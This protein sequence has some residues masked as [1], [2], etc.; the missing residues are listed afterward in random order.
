MTDANK[1]VTLFVQCLVDAI[2][3]EV[4]E[5]MV[6]VLLNLGST[7]H[8]PTD[9]TCCGQPAFNSGYRS[10]ARRQ[11]EKERWF[12][13]LQRFRAGIEGIISALMRGYGLKRCLWKGWQSFQSYVGLAIVTFNLQKIAELSPTK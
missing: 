10:Q 9:Q 12:K 1:N 6:Q 11:F 5:S 4:G 8:C 13:D 3:T 2:Y 7:V